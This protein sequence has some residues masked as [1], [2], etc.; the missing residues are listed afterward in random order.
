MKIKQRFF[1]N[2]DSK[3]LFI[4]DLHIGHKN[5]LNIDKRPYKDMV[6]MTDYIIQ[7]L[8]QKVRPNDLLFDLGDMFF[9]M[10]NKDCLEFLDKIP[11]KNLYKV[12]GNHDKQGQ[13]KG[14]QPALK[15]RFVM[16]EDILTITVVDDNKEYQKRFFVEQL[17]LA[18]KYNLP[19]VVHSREAA[20]D[21]YEVLKENKKYYIISGVIFALAAV[22][23]LV[24]LL[25]PKKKWR[26]K[27]GFHMMKKCALIF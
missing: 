14:T 1:N 4:S 22:L 18:N 6:E 7:E 21:T 19:I 27:I 5:I 15:D 17:K 9:A 23:L 8:N 24:F 12:M 13:Y 25:V 2:E 26:M 16:I 3:I 10:N 20:L 11:T